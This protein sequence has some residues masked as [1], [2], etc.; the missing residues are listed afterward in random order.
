MHPG[1]VNTNF[2]KNMKGMAGVYFRLSP[3]SRSPEKG[4]ETVIWL[5]SSTE[6]EGISGKYFIDKK[7]SRSN[8]VS[9][10]ESVQKRL[11]EES[12]KMTGIN[13]NS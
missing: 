3:F 11:W 10:D 7:E 1:G 2:G 12:Q 5:A 8:K 4:A 13:E 9:Y 6:I